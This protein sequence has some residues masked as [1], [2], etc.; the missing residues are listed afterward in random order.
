MAC[1]PEVAAARPTPLPPSRTTHSFIHHELCLMFYLVMLDKRFGN[2]FTERNC[3][4][5]TGTLLFTGSVLF[6]GTA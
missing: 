4:L 2:R 6:T 5:F 3:V 1:L